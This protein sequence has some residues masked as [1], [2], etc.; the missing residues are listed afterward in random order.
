MQH[1]EV[2]FS[3]RGKGLTILVKGYT[4]SVLLGLLGSLRLKKCRYRDNEN[5]LRRASFC[6]IKSR[7]TTKYR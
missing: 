5:G 3:L 7:E 6:K 2:N 1:N 4:G